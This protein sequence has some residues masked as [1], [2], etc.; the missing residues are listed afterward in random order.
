[1]PSRFVFSEMQ[2]ENGKIKRKC[3]SF[4]EIRPKAAASGRFVSKTEPGMS[5]VMNII[6]SSFA[7]LLGT[8]FL[9]LASLPPVPGA[10]PILN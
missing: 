3:N 6:H 2:V 8:P 1:V 9:V 4:N 7:E 10:S 5:F